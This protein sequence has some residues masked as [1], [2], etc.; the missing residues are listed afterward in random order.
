MIRPSLV[1]I[2]LAVAATAAPGD[3]LFTR[4]G[5]SGN[6][7]V[8]LTPV[9]GQVLYWDGSPKGIGSYDIETALSGKQTTLISGINLK[10][11]GGAS[12]LGSGN[13]GLA[14]TDIAGKPAAI[15]D[16]TAAFT[17]ALETKLAGISGVNTGDQNLS[18]Y[19]A[20]ATAAGLYQPIIA[21]GT[22]ALSKLSVNPL[23][24]GSHTGTQA[25]TTVTGL[26]TLATQSGTFSGTSSGTNTGDQ[27]LSGLLTSSI[28][29]STYAPKASPTFTGNAG[30]ADLSSSGL[31]FLNEVS[32]DGLI[33]AN[34]G[35]QGNGELLTNLN[36]ANITT[37]NIAR[38]RI[39]NALSANAAPITATTVTASGAVTVSGG[40][41]VSGSSGAVTI[42][43]SGTNQNVNLTPSGTGKV[44]SSRPIETSSFISAGGGTGTTFSRQLSD[45]V[46]TAGLR[47]TAND[48][49]EIN[50]GTA[51]AFRDL[52][53]RNI[54]ASG[55]VTTPSLSQTTGSSQ[56]WLLGP[57]VA[58]PYTY[59][60]TLNGTTRFSVNNGGGV[61]G[62]SFSRGGQTFASGVFNKLTLAGNT[63]RATR[64]TAGVGTAV[65]NAGTLTTVTGTGT[66]FTE[67]FTVGDT[68]TL[69]GQVEKTIAAIA[70]D[71]T[72]TVTS[73]FP[74][75][76]TSTSYTHPAGGVTLNPSGG[77]ASTG[78]SI[79]TSPTP[80]LALRTSAVNAGTSV[81]S[82]GGANATQKAGIISVANGAYS[83]QNFYIGSNFAE[84]AALTP[85]TSQIAI[86]TLGTRI[87][88]PLGF[89]S[90]PVANQITFAPST[91]NTFRVHSSSS[92][93][94]GTAMF[95]LDHAAGLGVKAGMF[96]TSQGSYGRS[97]GIHLALNAAND[98]TA[99][100]SADTKLFVREDGNVGIGNVTPG[101]KL[102]VTGN[103][104]A[105]GS[106]TIGGGT[107]IVSSGTTGADLVASVTP[108]AALATLGQA[109]V[110]LPHPAAI[111]SGWTHSGGGVYVSGSGNA[112]GYQGLE[113]TVS[114]LVTGA[115]Y[116][117]KFEVS[118]F[119][120]GSIQMFL[121][122]SGAKSFSQVGG[123]P[124]G[125]VT[126]F[127]AGMI[128]RS[129]Q[130]NNRFHIRCA[131]GFVGTIQNITLTKLP[132]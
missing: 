107:A 42:A 32:A 129:S 110:V 13:I 17:T 91:G 47:F 15:T 97:T 114:G 63:V 28:A 120:S 92:F 59:D 106:V 27:D 101:D 68:L 105:S 61:N 22:L 99:I 38:A 126:G 8:L 75:A 81:L 56:A 1:A 46:F 74:G 18:G 2:L 40:G 16:T 78:P 33:S 55:T 50:S 23:A 115:M 85:A 109:D 94:A 3:F 73:A 36:G 82:F 76:V 130:A 53:L 30:F 84:G 89:G 79:I 90:D 113:W 41:N 26:G 65:V 108:A 77:I 123:N 83:Q 52:N 48:T 128:C 70:S 9:N 119:T 132:Y 6:T 112:S 67:R 21:D 20:V 57:R 58:D 87:N 14:W 44:F 10:T 111:G 69:G 45:G 118:A 5:N 72:L 104:A 103:I 93:N 12:L 49:A 35:I 39:D 98:G 117:A 11:V 100:T 64:G 43:A 31:A 96:S 4:L 116:L 95:V 34:S 24:R 71:T 127:H 60:L 29:A 125:A 80:T 88:G 37:G 124:M 7:P 62:E 19:L 25:H 102:S 51:G 54:T 66:D 131:N 86:T 122:N 121:D